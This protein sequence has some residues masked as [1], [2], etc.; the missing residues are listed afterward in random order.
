MQRQSILSRPL[1]HTSRCHEESIDAE[2]EREQALLQA[3]REKYQATEEYLRNARGDGGKEAK[4]RTAEELRKAQ[5]VLLD[6]KRKAIEDAKKQEVSARATLLS[7]EQREASAEEEA[8]RKRKEQNHLA[9][10]E[11]LRLA[12]E[13]KKR[14]KI[15]KAMQNAKENQ[16]LQL[17]ASMRPSY[18]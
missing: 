4:I 17:M 14:M 6:H 1:R 7:F 8:E 2:W 5:E 3:K 18:R 13:K 11:N 16:D 10:L 9:M 12:E 15:E